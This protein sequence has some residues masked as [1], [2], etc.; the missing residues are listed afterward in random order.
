MNPSDDN[1]WRALVDVCKARGWSIR[2]T[3]LG[4]TMARKDG[5]VVFG[6]G[7]DAG[8]ALHAELLS[9]LRSPDRALWAIKERGWWR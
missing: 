3:P 5:A 1:A 2:P 7:R 6:A 4:H 9:R 8:P